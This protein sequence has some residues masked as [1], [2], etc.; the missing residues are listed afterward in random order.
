MKM[1]ERFAWRFVGAQRSRAAQAGFKRPALPGR[2]QRASPRPDCGFT[3]VELLIVIAVI[4]ILTSLLL[5]ALGQAKQRA[6]SVGCLNNERQIAMS[7]LIALDAEAGDRMGEP[8]VADW[9]ADEVGRLE[10]GWMCP[11]APLPRGMQSVRPDGYNRGTVDSAWWTK[12]WDWVARTMLRGLEGRVVDPKYR[13]GGYAFNLWLTGGGHILAGEQPDNT[14]WTRSLWFVVSGH[15]E[16]PGRT[17]VT[18]DGVTQLVA[19]LASDLAPTSLTYGVDLR[20]ELGNGFMPNLALPRH[21]N[22]PNRVP[23][24]WPRSATLPGAVN[25]SFFDGHAE[26]ISTERLWQL[27]WH[28]GYQPPAKRPGL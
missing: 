18:S 17:P 1:R 25:V 21:G 20:T 3:L 23:D 24:R 13:A 7:Y 10:K 5:P 8:A 12:E 9:I 14:G 22:R 15:I 28:R 6:R 16:H 4:A 19:P 11:S 2:T 26:L 27:Y